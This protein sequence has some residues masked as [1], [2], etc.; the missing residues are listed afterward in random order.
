VRSGF[1]EH[2]QRTFSKVGG[3]GGGS[4]G[5]NG[6]RSGG[7]CGR[8]ACIAPGFEALWLL[9][10]LPPLLQVAKVPLASLPK[11]CQASYVEIYEL[12]K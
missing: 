12:R 5:V 4:W 8:L 6:P 3:R 11:G 9:P 2:A 10:P 7:C 1:V